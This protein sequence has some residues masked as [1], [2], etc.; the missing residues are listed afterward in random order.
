VVHRILKLLQDGKP[1][2]E[3]L[4]KL[5]KDLPAIGKISS[6]REKVADE[7]ERESIR[8]KEIEYMEKKLGRIY[9]GLISGITNFGFWV[10]LD[11]IL[12]EGMV[13]L[14]DLDDDY[15]VYNPKKQQLKG[16]HT[17]RVFRLGERVKVQ[18]VRVDPRLKQIDFVLLS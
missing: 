16:R 6:E 5:K 11:H 1:N 12:V 10:K 9:W 3:K 4:R 8:I 17:K 2:V 15:Y 7:A 14:S 13:R 18:V